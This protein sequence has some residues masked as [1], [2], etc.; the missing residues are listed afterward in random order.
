MFRAFAETVRK[1]YGKARG[2][3]NTSKTLAEQER[4]NYADRHRKDHLNTFLPAN[5]KP[6]LWRGFVYVFTW[7]EILS[8]SFNRQHGC[9]C[10]S[11]RER[12]A[13]RSVDE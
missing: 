9:D 6:L 10:V 5:T 1:Q 12:F 8:L 7:L 2:E 3:R 11:K 4:G 13:H